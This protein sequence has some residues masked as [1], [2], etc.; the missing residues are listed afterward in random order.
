MRFVR[1]PKIDGVVRELNFGIDVGKRHD[2]SAIVAAVLTYRGNAAHYVVPFLKRMPLGMPYPDQVDEFIR[3]GKAACHQF[4]EDMNWNTMRIPRIF[5]D[6]TGVGD[7]VI[8]LLRQR[9]VKEVGGIEPCRFVG[10]DRIEYG[11]GSYN[12]GKEAFVSRL[13]VLMEGNKIHLPST[14]EAEALA[15]ELLTFDI[16]IDSTTG[17]ATYGAIRPG[18]HDDLVVALGL[19]CLRG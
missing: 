10:G 6:V 5:V 14:G 15:N 19:A 1:A 9:G 8:D 3:I 7:P 12:I 16:D 13:Q 17:K 18:T 2:P 11:G 4:C